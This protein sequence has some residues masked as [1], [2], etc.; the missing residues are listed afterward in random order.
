MPGGQVIGRVDIKV[1]PDT[2]DF[3]SRLKAALERIEK[4]VKFAGQVKLEIDKEAMKR[5]EKELKDWA[6]RISPLKVSVHPHMVIGATTF[7]EKRLDYLTRPRLVPLIPYLNSMATNRAAKGIATFVAALSGGRIV[8]DF[9]TNVKD[10]VK[11]LDKALPKFALVSNAVALLVSLLLTSVSNMFAFGSSL[12]SIGAIALTLPATFAAIGIGVGVLIAAFKD[13]N[14][15]LPEVK[16]SLSKMQDLISGNFWDKAEGPMRKMIDELLPQFSDGLG[17]AATKYGEFFGALSTALTGSLDGAIGGMFA[18]LAESI[19][20]AKGAAEPLAGAIATLGEAGSAYLPR[21]AEWVVQI[22]T[23]FDAWLTRISGDGTLDQWVNNGLQALSDL[24]DVLYNL[25]GIFSGIADAANAA[26]GSSLGMMADTLERVHAVVDS[27][28]FQ[29]GLT[30]AFKGAHDA[31]KAIS[32]GAGPQLSEFFATL[33]DSLG[34]LLPLIGSGL[35]TALGALA[36]GFTALLN[37]GGVEELFKGINMAFSSLA[38]VMPAVGEALG[39]IGRLLGNLASSAGPLLTVALDAV[40]QAFE[41]LAPALHPLIV[42]LSGS[43]LT[44]LEA[45]APVFVTIGSILG[46]VLV[47]AV[48][49]LTPTLALIGEV[50]AQ[51]A[52]MVSQ[53]LMAVLPLIPPLLQLVAAVLEPLLEVVMEIIGAAL[54]PLIAAF[55]ALVTALLPVIEFVT[56]LVTMLLEHLAPVLTWL[57]EAIVGAVTGVIEGVTEIFGGFTE[58]FEGFKTMFSGGMSEFWDGIVQVVKGFG[59]VLL[60]VVKVLW[61][62]GIVK[63]FSLGWTAIKGLFKSAGTALKKVWD[64]ALFNLKAAWSLLWTGI[65]N[66]FKSWW[67]SFKSEWTGVGR[68]LKEGAKAVWN[69]VKDAFKAGLRRVIENVKRLPSDIKGIFSNASTFLVGVGEKI[70]RGLITGI[71]NMFGSVKEK[72]G[73][74]TAKLKDWKGPAAKDRVLLV[75]PGQ[76]VIESFVRGLESR[77]GLVRQSLTSLTSEV[78]GWDF[79]APTTSAFA[80]LP[81][82]IDAAMSGG[83]AVAG[84]DVN[85]RIDAQGTQTT[86]DDIADAVLFGLRRASTGGVYA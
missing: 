1:M 78:Q 80:G 77:F 73:S 43:L 50:F 5:V 24:G 47:Q 33:G 82:S 57:G 31:I 39:T 21:M 61:N 22:A 42:L 83:S 74:L 40:L 18:Q 60:G 27:P 63:A 26:G 71:G 25:G 38:P 72:L 67:S 66:Y 44:I 45:L 6:E 3:K 17:L 23:R 55:E 52:P 79:G 37:S 20:I 28:A 62:I 84:R 7:I 69:A 75:K 41:A 10:F 4:Q 59:T 36:E 70:I 49:A 2:R 56:Q 48:E 85:L 13:F 53:L 30:S 19:S 15:V 58:I 76:M 16:K 46:E 12:A 34:T 81:G 9:A 32:D 65:R 51:L 29:S 86:A 64:T 35:G 54:P 14:K 8:K 68:E 11:D